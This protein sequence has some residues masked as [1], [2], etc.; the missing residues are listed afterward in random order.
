MEPSEKKISAFN[1]VNKLIVADLE[2]NLFTNRVTRSGAEVTLTHTQFRIL[3]YLASNLDRVIPKSKI[4]AILHAK[5]T[6]LKSNTVDV[7]IARLRQKIDQNYFPNLIHT[8]WGKGYV[9]SE[10]F[11]DN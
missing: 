1:G 8:A 5:S 10:K 2:I 7:H 11:G 6:R 9:L 4:Y 3:L